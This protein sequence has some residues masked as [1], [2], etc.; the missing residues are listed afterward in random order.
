MKLPGGGLPVLIGAVLLIIAS[1]CVVLGMAAIVNFMCL[2]LH[3]W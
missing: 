3:Y 1:S 2:H